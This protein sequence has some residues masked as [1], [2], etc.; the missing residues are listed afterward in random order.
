MER[1]FNK[2]FVGALDDTAYNNMEEY[3]KL[4]KDMRFG[5]LRNHTMAMIKLPRFD[6][7]LILRAVQL[8]ACDLY[9]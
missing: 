4:V 1:S 3:E 5:D 9:V 6:G 7:K 8:A 2:E